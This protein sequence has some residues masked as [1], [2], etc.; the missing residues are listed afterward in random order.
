MELSH[1]RLGDCHYGR[2]PL[3]SSL[4]TAKNS[5]QPGYQFWP[6][7]T[8]LWQNKPIWKVLFY[9]LCR[10]YLYITELYSDVCID[11]LEWYIFQ[12]AVCVYSWY[13]EDYPC[14]ICYMYILMVSRRSSLFTCVREVWVIGKVFETIPVP[15]A[16]SIGAYSCVY[17]IICRRYGMIN[18]I[19]Q[20][21]CWLKLILHSSS[22][23]MWQSRLIN[24]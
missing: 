6:N 1:G 14:S 10:W 16:K 22:A 13:K 7:Y 20:G 2:P 11:K 9:V 24:G 8:S 3:T 5:L 12:C 19:A 23:G 21:Q 17:P 15:M 4:F 18:D